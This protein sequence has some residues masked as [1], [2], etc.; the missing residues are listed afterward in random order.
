V[1]HH[2]QLL[3][4][5]VRA[6]VLFLVIVCTGAAL[7]GDP[8]Q[9]TRLPGDLEPVTR[10]YPDSLGRALK[11]LGRSVD[12][13]QSGR[14]GAALA[15]M[16]AAAAAQTTA[17]G[18]Y[19]TLYRAKAHLAMD[20]TTEALD[21]FRALQKDYPASP[22]MQEAILGEVQAL[23]KLHNA[24]AAAVVLAA[25]ALPENAETLFIQARVL[26]DTG[27]S[28]RAAR[29]YLKL[30][31]DFV[32]SKQSPL[33]QNRLL[34]LSP[35]LLGGEPGYAA[36]LTRTE[37]LIGAG[38]YRD[39]SALLVRLGR[40][41]APNREGDARRYLLLARAAMELGKAS[42][43]LPYLSKTDEHNPVAQA[44]ALYI[45]AVCH[46]RLKS[47]SSF[48]AD[49]DLAVRL[50]PDSLYTEKILYSVA[51]Y[52][53]VADRADEASAAYQ[54][55]ADKFPS[56]SNAE[57]A[58]WK[59]ALY[60][61]ADKKYAAALRGFW[62]YLQA[63]PTPRGAAAPIFWMGRCYQ[64]LGDPASALALYQRATALG[65]HA[66]YGQRARE[67]AAILGKLGP[68][69][70]QTVTAVDFAQVLQKTDAIH[71]E[72]F[73]IAEPSAEAA[74][75]IERARQLLTADLPGFA[76]SEL[77]AGMRRYPQERALSYVMSRIYSLD[78]D[79][80]GVFSA[81]RRA[82]PDYDTRSVTTLPEKIWALLFPFEHWETV[83]LQAARNNLDPSLVLA[84]IRQESAFSTTARSSANARGLMQL[85]P[86][87]G[88]Q[89]A[90]GAGVRYSAAR[91]FRA[92]TN[93]TLGT[94]H[95][96]T[97]LRQFSGKEELALAAYNAGDARVE[98]WLIRF[99]NID[100]AEFVE[101]I[102]F[103]E[104]RSYVKQVLTNKAYYSLLAGSP[105]ATAF[106]ATAPDPPEK[107]LSV[108]KT[109][110]TRMKAA[111]SRSLPRTAPRKRARPKSALSS[112]QRNRR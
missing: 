39:A 79:Y 33:A 92:D 45:R 7:A 93:I 111:P 91:L 8:P 112:S 4:A 101:R 98:Q 11:A 70:G 51:T 65:N 27:E 2:G 63:Y 13:L 108:K 1:T 15:E 48:L 44:Q 50:Y 17:V 105:G 78:K 43:V 30:Y 36:Q 60:S 23:L 76:I 42:T 54:E 46:R 55:L 80:S 75:V 73:G 31:T 95:L 86:S 77:R 53:D 20:R 34:A 29:L 83:R 57:R 67:A 25:A 64:K 52:F 84:V 100:M 85:L 28:E 6:V 22:L 90:G 40:S 89:L 37:N 59:V 18:D 9:A 12:Y 97:L 110:A 24:A 94:R 32:T 35:R 74:Q 87:T 71:G 66:Y 5:A 47:E 109:P 102:P 103:S 19:F 26:E 3:N 49:R 88:R 62:N 58:L 106:S 82:I 41:A 14:F 56:G 107:E 10:N 68:A 16:P 69:D 104:T 81:L 99:G 61:Y 96:A 72:D 38:L 21:F